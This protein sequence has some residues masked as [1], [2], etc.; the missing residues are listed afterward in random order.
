MKLVQ[1]GIIHTPFKQSSGT[2]IQPKYGKD[3]RGEVEVFPEFAEG[4][5]DLEGFDRI[6]L[7]FG[8]HRARP[9]GLKQV[10][11][12]DTVER[13]VFAIRS[14]SRPNPICISPVRLLEREGNRLMVAEVDMLDGTPLYDIK[15]Y[16]ARVDAYPDAKG[17]WF[18]SA[19][20]EREGVE[21]ADDRFSSDE[22]E[23]ND[24]R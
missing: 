4:L 20:G 10:P 8:A 16:I 24:P 21:R 2:P 23:G 15:P 6:W 14:P 9:A 22:S 19:R 12:R 13:G 3:A 17:G 7:I 11:Y 1:I 5:D 18:D